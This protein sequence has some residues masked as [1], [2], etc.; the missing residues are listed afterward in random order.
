MENQNSSSEVDERI[1]R[2]IRK[3]YGVVALVTIGIALVAI[4][5]G[6]LVD[7]SK[8]TQPMYMLIG[9]VVSAPITVWVNFSLIK[10][11][12]AAITSEIE[13]QKAHQDQ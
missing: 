8:G 2:I 9:L 3:Q 7:L 5:G 13:E 12:L 1:K 6:Y 4:G 10:R 11:K